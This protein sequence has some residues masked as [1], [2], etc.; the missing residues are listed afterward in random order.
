MQVLNYNP[1]S[2]YA[3]GEAFFYGDK[4]SALSL[5]RSPNSDGLLGIGLHIHPDCDDIDIVIK[6]K[7]YFSNDAKNFTCASAPALVANLCGTPHA[8]YVPNK[9]EALMYG[10]RSPFKG[11]ESVTSNNLNLKSQLYELSKYKTGVHQLFK[12]KYTFAK[13]FVNQTEIKADQNQCEDRL[14]INLSEKNILINDIELKSGSS[15]K[16]WQDNLNIEMKESKLLF[17]QTIQKNQE[18]V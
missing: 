2:Y 17:L 1:N 8:V 13:L 15:I 3:K 9:S 18:L 10:F 14:L 16:N 12:S 11:G 6:G 7:V 4:K 5:F